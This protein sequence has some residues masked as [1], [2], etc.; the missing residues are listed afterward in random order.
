[1]KDAG[2]CVGKPEQWIKCGINFNKTAKNAQQDF[3][4]KN[5]TQTMINV[6]TIFLHNIF[7]EK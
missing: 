3:N 5:Y 1:M 7:K 6:L 4:F 2:L